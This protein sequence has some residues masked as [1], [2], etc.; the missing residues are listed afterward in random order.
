MQL[1]ASRHGLV[2]AI[3][4]NALLF[5][6]LHGGNIKP[7]MELALALAN[8]LL[9]AVMISLYAIKEGSLW[10]VCA[11]HSA[12]N[13]LLGVGFGLEVSGSRVAVQS[14]VVDLAPV[15]GAPWWLTGGAFGP[16]ASVA[17]TGVLLAGVIYFLATGAMKPRAGYAAPLAG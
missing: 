4:I 10:G 14:L 13:T 5:A 1:V 11:W 16:E 12:W 15:A 6:L 2:L 8:L 9:F 3:V 17:T 7:S